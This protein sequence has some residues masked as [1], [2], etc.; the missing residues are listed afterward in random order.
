MKKFFAFCLLLFFLTS[1][2]QEKPAF[3]EDIQHFKQ[4]D[5]NTPPPKNAIFFVGSSSFTKWTDVNDYFPGKTI[6]NRGFGGSSLK[7][8]NFY[9]EELLKPYAPKQIIIYCGENDF[10]TD[11]TLT[12]RQVF[13][14]YKTFYSEIRKLYPEI[15]VSYVSIKLSPR[16]E[17]FWPKFIATNTLI[18]KFMIRKK[19]ADYIDITAAMNGPDG[20]VRKDLF[21]EDMLHMKPEGY[22]IWK[23]QMEPYLK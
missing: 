19:N 13:R 21:L 8:L 17:N 12:P 1:H 2:A 11:E 22:R 6:I 23:K 15:P 5:L 16:R 18:E 9:A 4:L 7:D 14:R 10:A 20:K 3:Y